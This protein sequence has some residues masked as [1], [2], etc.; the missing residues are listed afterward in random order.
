MNFFEWHT[1]AELHESKIRE[2][3]IFLKSRLYLFSIFKVFQYFKFT[4]K[5]SGKKRSYISPVLEQMSLDFN[6]KFSIN[7]IYMQCYS[8]NAKRR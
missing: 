3:N 4:A 7:F 1:L 5:L 6:T 2:T 8:V